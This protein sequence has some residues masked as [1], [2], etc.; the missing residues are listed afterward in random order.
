MTHEAT[1]AAPRRWPK[2]IFIGLLGFFG[3]L[4]ALLIGAYFWLDSASG[5][6]FIISQIEAIEMKNGMTIN[7]ASLD[8]SI[9]RQ[10]RVNGLKLS[11][12]KGVFAG[13]DRIDVDW[14][15]L[16]Y[17]F[18]HIDI[19]S[20]IAPKLQLMRVP[21]FKE[22]PPD[23]DPILPNLDIDIAKLNVAAI[24]IAPAVTGKRHVLRLDGHAKIADQ[25]AQI[26]ATA[27]ALIAG[28]VAGGDKFDLTLDAVPDDNKFDLALDLDAPA[29]GLI[30]GLSGIAKPMT[31]KIKGK[32]SW[33]VWHGSILAKSG[34]APFA[35][36]KLTAK[37]GRFTLIGNGQP[38][39]LLA[40]GKALNLLEP[41]VAIN[42]SAAISERR[43]T[44]DGSVRNQNFVLNSKGGVSFAD[45]LFDNLQLDIDLLNP[46][47]LADNIAGQNIRLQALL[48]GDFAMP[49]VSYQLTAARFA[50]GK[51][52]IIGLRASGL[53][54]AQNGEIQI[55][56]NGSARRITGLDA[57]SM[58]LLEN[59]RINGDLAYSKGRILSDN[60][61]L[62]S[63]QIDATAI[64]LV[65]L[66][67][68][69]YSGGL[70]GRVGQYRVAGV[71]LFNAETNA[72][73]THGKGGIALSGTIKARSSKITNT[74]LRDFL[75]HGSS[76]LTANFRYGTDGIIRVNS[77]RIAAPEIRLTDGAGSYEAN[78]KLRFGGKGI[79]NRYGP[80]A[81]D[82]SGYFDAP[83]ARIAA[84]R[85][86]FGVGIANV[87]ADV[88]G[89]AR[90]YLVT[91]RGTSDYGAWD[92]AF[93]ILSGRGPLTIEIKRGDFAGVALSGRIVQSKSGPFAGR[94]SAD[95]SGITGNVMLSAVDGKQRAIVAATAH[96]ARLPGPANLVV[97]RAIIDADIILYEQPQITA[98][99]Q[100]AEM[101]SRSLSIHSGRAKI[102]YRGGRGSAQILANGRSGVP[103]HIAANAN[104]TPILWTVSAKG[105]ANGINFE[106]QDP[107]RIIPGKNGYRLQPSKIALSRGSIQLS[108]EYGQGISIESRLNNIDLS[109]FNP[110]YPRLAVSGL[111][112]GSFDF[113]QSSAGGMPIADARLS[114]KDFTRAS[115]AGSSQPVDLNINAQL[116]AANGKL[117]AIFR[118]GGAVIGR[119]QAGIKP[120]GGGAGN[121]QN[122][123]LGAAL[124]G[125]IRYNGPADA[126]FSLAGLP[127]QHLS[128]PLGVAADFSGR[129]Q[130]PQV[131]GVMR[132]N[133]L[134]YNN[135]SYGT[136]LTNIRL[137]GNFVNERFEVTELTAKAGNGI[138]SGT[139]FVSLSAEQGFPMQLDLVTENAKL[140]DRG[141]LATSATGTIRITQNASTPAIITG[142]LA[143]PETRYKLVT[144]SNNQV[145]TLSGVRRKIKNGPQVFSADADPISS[146]PKDWKLDVKLTA[147]NKVYVSGMGLESEWSADLR[148]TGTTSV[149]I[150]AGKLNMLRGTIGFAGRSFKLSTGKIAFDG[151]SAAN[152]T[153]FLAASSDI[154]G[155]TANIEIEGRAYNPKLTVSS[156]PS[157]PQD[158]VMAR[159]LFGSS[160]MQL[161]PVQALQLAG[162]LN[163]LRGGGSGFNPIGIVQS[164]LGIDRLR[165]LAPDEE[166]GRGTAVAA[167]RYITDKIYV[168]IVTDSRG[169][170]ASQ[171][172]LTLGRGLSVLSQVGS[173]GGSNAN[174]RYRKNY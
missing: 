95:G 72:K 132:A 98:D 150:F 139:G 11:D 14:R 173:F 171:I 27:N 64:L 50:I 170:T 160:I 102:D 62:R 57:Q 89:S 71:G 53:A 19:R 97:G 37:D 108:G 84:Q 46:Q 145:A 148:I 16:A 93:D 161:S 138:V 111:A 113:T 127:D 15:P 34:D 141:D 25:R 92:G 76:L 61:K 39:L 69:A 41:V 58:R 82:L 96:Q 75:G 172:E 54:K 8:G 83:V 114:I 55:P 49:Q 152:P 110:L 70:T 22:T 90:G 121:W 99:V 73:I 48:S 1:A 107:A 10:L 33:Q 143:L 20:L 32:G 23:D 56:V 18:G 91:A 63:A 166:H 80:F 94:L 100:M 130:S 30:A 154:D 106:T 146:A 52:S 7:V 169:Y 28:D 128:G 140:A 45:N 42:L 9:Y 165:I 126:L 51:Q 153:L 162:S 118:R 125:G 3:L 21:M 79:S 159:I 168:E 137:R 4:L 117:S 35:D 120:L 74:G 40:K 12:T 59:I 85:P 158:E 134:T 87:I 67:K 13:S 109:I 66:N 157:L 105:R 144:Q 135:S 133:A 36:L 164:G 122:R 129:V 119:M 5:K 44:I 103:F 131:N 31:A 155:V 116:A 43:A 124:T 156:T 123:M 149:P 6:R 115:S 136:K 112:S 163:S 151:A 78:G 24:E 65:D 174:I 29:G 167:G 101:T 81:I 142:T 26:F 17:V 68:G 104:L 77:V 60:L 86:G 88:R 2:R 47:L 147:P 38:A